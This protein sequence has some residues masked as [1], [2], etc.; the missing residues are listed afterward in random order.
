MP[1]GLGGT[2]EPLGQ[3]APGRVL[4]KRG[5]KEAKAHTG[6][7]EASHNM[8]RHHANHSWSRGLL[9]SSGSGQGAH[10]RQW[11]GGGHPVN[12]QTWGTPGRGLTIET[13]AHGESASQ[14]GHP[15]PDSVSLSAH[16][17]PGRCHESQCLS[18]NPRGLREASVH[19]LLSS[20]VFELQGDPL[21]VTLCPGA[22]Q[23]GAR[24]AA[25]TSRPVTFRPYGDFS[26]PPD[27]LAAGERSH[28]EGCGL[29]GGPP[30]ST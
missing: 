15:L 2:R 28:F 4:D 26:K 19:Q 16:H 14:E 21:R 18:H 12:H 1:P 24:V 6:R 11:A 27:P 3:P 22:G 9:L 10:V 17:E 30:S 23:Q 8:G 5:P 20:G 25:S 13:C 29:G 7:H